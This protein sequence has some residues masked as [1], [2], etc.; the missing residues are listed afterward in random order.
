MKNKILILLLFSFSLSVM[1]DW[2]NIFNHTYRKS[3]IS[4][5]N[6]ETMIKL[7][8]PYAQCC[9]IYVEGK[10]LLNK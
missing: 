3:W 9:N 10:I 4:D 7:S 1:A 6:F 8:F 2:G 5:R